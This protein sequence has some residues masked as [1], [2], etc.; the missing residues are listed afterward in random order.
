MD[1]GVPKKGDHYNAM[2]H[3]KFRDWVIKHL[4]PIWKG[5]IL[6]FHVLDNTP[7]HIGGMRN[8]FVMTKPECADYLRGAGLYKVYV[9]RDDGMPLHAVKISTRGQN[10]PN[11]PGDRQQRSSDRMSTTQWKIMNPICYEHGLRQGLKLNEGWT[12][13]FTPPYLCNFQLIKLFWAYIKNS[14]GRRHFNRRDMAWI[15]SEFAKRA[16]CTTPSQIR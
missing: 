10:L 16:H 5:D 13:I 8:P 14:I 7:Y 15:A 4:L 3:E 6:N 9:C 1:T 2:D 11:L 12:I